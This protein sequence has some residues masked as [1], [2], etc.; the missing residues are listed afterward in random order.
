MK[1]LVEGKQVGEVSYLAGTLN[2]LL[3][4][5]QTEKIWRSTSDEY[6]PNND[7]KSHYVSLSRNMTSAH[8]RDSSRWAY[9]V[10]ID[11]DKLSDKYKIVPYSFIGSLGTNYKT[12][13][14]LRISS[15]TEYQDR[16]CWLKFTKWNAFEIPKVLFDKLSNNIANLSEDEK[17]KYKYTHKWNGKRNV[18]SH[19]K[20]VEQHRFLSQFGGPPK[21]LNRD[22]LD[23]FA[24]F[25]YNNPN[26]SEQEERIWLKAESS[27]I[28]IHN[29]IRGIVVPRPTAIKIIEIYEKMQ[30]DTLGFMPETEEERAIAVLCDTCEDLFGRDWIYNK[31]QLIMY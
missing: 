29:C 3:S 14:Q 21:L 27:D 6:N 11:G 16:S 17:T 4:I 22:N 2:T 10:V 1:I 31:K 12:K 19:G 23:E 18:G 5:I 15:L 30:D 20:I 13:K 7:A 28:D 25:L 9:G 24:S 8:N 26:I